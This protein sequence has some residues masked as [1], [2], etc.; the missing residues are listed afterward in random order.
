MSIIEKFLT[1]MQGT[2]RG[3]SFPV[4]TVVSSLTSDSHI[5]LRGGW[6]EGV[7]SQGTDVKLAEGM[8]HEGEDGVRIAYPN[9][10]LD[11]L[12][13]SPDPADEDMTK[14]VSMMVRR[15]DTRRAEYL[16]AVKRVAAW[17]GP[18]FDF[19]EWVALISARPTIDVVS[20]TQQSLVRA[21]KV[22]IVLL[23]VGG[24]ARDA[25]AI[26]EDGGY[27]V[28]A[29]TPWLTQQGKA[30][31]AYSSERPPVEAFTSFI[32]GLSYPG[33]AQ[34][35]V[36]SGVFEGTINSIAIKMLKVA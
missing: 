10:D 27:A 3:V 13:S 28:A 12:F 31:N 14:E 18:E 19:S 15:R 20:Q 32:G 4:D 7:W 9:A 35:R 25:L 11:V 5:V 6:W 21:R 36:K 29:E 8:L 2:H 30:W 17:A 22:G 34:L 16:Q 24:Q 26:D 1:G 33:E 23:Y